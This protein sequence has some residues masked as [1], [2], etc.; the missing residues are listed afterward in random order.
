MRRGTRCGAA[1][2]RPAG[3]DRHCYTAE[4]DRAA[5]EQY[6][7]LFVDLVEDF[8]SLAESRDAEDVRD[9]LSGYFD[10]ARTIVE[11][12][13]GAIEKF[14]GDA[15][16][17]VWGVPR[18]RE[19]DAERAVR[20][21][22]EIIDAVSTFGERAEVPERAAR[23]GVVTGQV[24][25]QTN[26]GEGIVVGD[27]VNT[28]ARIQAAAEPGKVLVDDVTRQVSSAAIAYEDA[29]EHVLKGKD[30]PVHL[31]HP[32]RVVSGVGGKQREAS[33][34]ARAGGAN[35][36]LRLIKDLFHSGIEHGVAR[37]VAVS[38]W[39]ALAR[40]DFVGSLNKK[41]STVWPTTSCSP[42]LGRCLPYG[43]GVAHWALAEMVR[44]RLGIPEE[45]AFEDA[46]SKLDAGLYCWIVSASDREF[47]VLRLGRCS[48]SP[49]PLCAAR[50]CS[51][52]GG[53]SSS[54]S[55]STSRW[56]WSSRTC[57]GP[58]A[59]VCSILHP[60]PT[61]VV[62]PARDLHAR[63]LP[64][65]RG[66][67]HKGGPEA[68]AGRPRLRPRPAGEGAMAVL[69]AGAGI[70]G[71][72]KDADRLAGG[73]HCCTR[74]RRSGRSPTGACWWPTATASPWRESSASS[75]SLPA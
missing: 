50:S 53:C 19:D 7:F 48:A 21:A 3:R 64:A 70:A 25:A 60:S 63:P 20:A 36:D 61:R 56:S 5:R 22:L 37:L 11:R 17:A 52:A 31:W 66:E 62:D 32:T 72:G 1:R 57:S 30:E 41:T 75:T 13:G 54:A 16:M 10:A 12:Y 58:S 35:T 55:P 8:T 44:Q 74:S 65:Q 29:G 18:A 4:R 69:T 27:R 49:S 46:I 9:L 67:H 14:I 59:T 39:P 2:H 71:R 23:A 24:A 42:T 51:R 15:V 28:A 43:D 68:G 33:L 40:R 34:E 73:G 45:L 38:G 6:P 47:L 26:S